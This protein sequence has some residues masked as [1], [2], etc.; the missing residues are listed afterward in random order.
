M[1]RTRRSRSIEASPDAVWRVVADP[2][3]LPRWWP[4]VQRVESVEADRW[5]V[6]M[7]TKRGRGVRLDQ[8]LLE[9][10]PQHR[11]LWAQDI[12]GTP[13]Q[14][15]LSEAT[16]EVRLAGD[17]PTIVTL[18]MRQKLRGTARLGSP[19]VRRAARAQLDDALAGLADVCA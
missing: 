15:F 6:V 7:G 9:D 19:M 5:T 16:T 8:R 11:R 13:F 14:G 17:G 10:E 12:E 4:K 2:H 3:H 1:P 18:E